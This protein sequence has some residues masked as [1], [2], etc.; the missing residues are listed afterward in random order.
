MRTAALVAALL[1]LSP[2]ALAEEDPATP[3]PLGCWA[4]LVGGEWHAK[5][6]WEAGTPFE[7]RLVAEW[8]PAQSFLRFKIFIPIQDGEYT[9]YDSVYYW[10]P[11]L[12]QP[13]YFRASYA[14]EASSGTFKIEADTVTFI[15]PD[16]GGDPRKLKSTWQFVTKDRCR[17]TVWQ[18]QGEAEPW[19]KLIAADYVRGAQPA[20]K[21]LKMRPPTPHHLAPLARF[22]GDRFKVTGKLANGTPIAGAIEHAWGVTHQ[23]MVSKTF[24][25]REEK[26]TLGFLGFTWWDEELKAFRMIEFSAFGVYSEG[27][28]SVN[29]DT[30]ILAFT[31]WSKKAAGV[32]AKHYRQWTLFETD[33]RITWYVEEK[34]E[35]GWVKVTESMKGERSGE[36]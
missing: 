11:G 25:T 4:G 27:T 18:E 36:E 3:H 34:T 16:P 23:V 21:L 29:Q 32:V 13:C 7:S 15:Y 10:H 26:E 19:T 33:D 6:A 24:I 5:G 1:I 31:T 12:A 20:R 35:D 9:R 17:W 22:V 8:G 2:I 30:V 14:G 28:I